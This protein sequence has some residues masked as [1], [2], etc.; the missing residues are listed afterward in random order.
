MFLFFMP[1]FCATTDRG[2][3]TRLLGFFENIDD[4]AVNFTVTIWSL[5]EM[6]QIIIKYSGIIPENF[7]GGKFSLVTFSVAFPA[8]C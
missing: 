1:F 6:F 5:I 4:K 8:H 2:R 7:E 3:I